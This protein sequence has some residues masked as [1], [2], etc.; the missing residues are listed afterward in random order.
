M[1][2]VR[3]AVGSLPQHQTVRGVVESPKHST[4]SEAQ[5]QQLLS[6]SLFY[7][8]EQLIKRYF[9][10][11]GSHHTLSS[12]HTSA[13]QKPKVKETLAQIRCAN[14]SLSRNA[15]ILT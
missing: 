14:S 10:Y 7:T 3:K 1:F 4:E 12:N 8:L 15:Q 6:L 5:K 2:D 11:W 13:P 9:I